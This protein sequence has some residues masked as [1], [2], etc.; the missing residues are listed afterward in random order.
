VPCRESWSFFVRFD[1]RGRPVKYILHEDICE[2]EEED[3][4]EKNW[5]WTERRLKLTI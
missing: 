2:E 1:P 4:G 5:C 3:V